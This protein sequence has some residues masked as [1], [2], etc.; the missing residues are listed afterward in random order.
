M[1]EVWKDIP[2]FGGHYMA[3]SLGRIKSKVRVVTKR[4]RGRTVIQVYGGKI[5]APEANHQGYRLVHLSIRNIKMVVA[6]HRLVL[7]AFCGQCPK[8]QEAC[9][10]DGNSLN[11]RADN[12][13]WD[14]HLNNNR[15]RQ[16]HGTYLTGEDHP[17]SKLTKEK[18]EQIREATGTYKA[19]GIR[20]NIGISQVCR[21]KRRECW[22]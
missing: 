1:T 3:S 5:L 11:N 14:T 19:I 16:K 6:I 21:I 12:L 17:M 4:W 10:N 2:G 13:R 7:L 22:T 18:V 20:F 9:H 8:G 15:D